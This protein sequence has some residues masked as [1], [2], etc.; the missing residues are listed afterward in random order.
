MMKMMLQMIGK[1]NMYDGQFDEQYFL[2]LF[3]FYIVDM[4][5]II[6]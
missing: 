6:Y 2:Y 3:C 5:I 4:M 1:G